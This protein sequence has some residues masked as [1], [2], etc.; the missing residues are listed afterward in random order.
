MAICYLLAFDC[1]SSQRLTSH[2]S[3]YCATLPRASAAVL[4]EGGNLWI[5][6][7]ISSEKESVLIRVAFMLPIEVIY[8][9]RKFFSILLSFDS[10]LYVCKASARHRDSWS[11]GCHREL[12]HNKT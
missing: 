11:R 9:V 5:C 6:D 4:S 12:L 2:A 1:E 3:G 10:H 8:G 7:T